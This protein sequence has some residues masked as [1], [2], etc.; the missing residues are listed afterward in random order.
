MYS[1]HLNI[2]VPENMTQVFENVYKIIEDN[3]GIPVINQRSLSVS[4]LEHAGDETVNNIIVEETHNAESDRYYL[5]LT[6][7]PSNGC[8]SRS[9]DEIA[10]L[11][12]IISNIVDM[13][14]SLRPHEEEV[15][16][17]SF[18]NKILKEIGSELYSRPFS[19][20]LL[21]LFD[22]DVLEPSQTS[23]VMFELQTV[24]V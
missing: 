3:Y 17:Y 20:A 9:L 22:F 10:K 5:N 24:I 23:H 11:L 16:T 4:I 15:I 2:S 8:D 1:I 6:N 7:H 19:Y 12:S 14:A 13:L 18:T 21:P